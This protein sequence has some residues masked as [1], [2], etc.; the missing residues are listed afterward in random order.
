MWGGVHCHNMGVQN[1]NRLFSTFPSSLVPRR[2]RGQCAGPI[3][4]H[5]A[6]RCIF[7]G[8][9]PTNREHVLARW[10]SL[11][12]VQ[13]GRRMYVEVDRPGAPTTRREPL[14]VFD[15]IAKQICASCNAGW[16]ADLEGSVRP[17]ISP[18]VQG[19]R[20]VL[21][22]DA[23][24]QIARWTIKTA[25]MARYVQSPPELATPEMLQWLR[26]Q[27]S[28]PPYSAV[29]LGRFAGSGIG[30]GASIQPPWSVHLAVHTRRH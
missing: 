11:L 14:K 9:R 22:P 20:V 30:R 16:M 12:V 17:L 7:C 24:N 28:A 13:P 25:V 26:D 8:G 23:Q 6:A 2:G 27:P 4:R 18:M 21:P 1:P 3:I 15:L 19:Q 5:M 29:W 10:L